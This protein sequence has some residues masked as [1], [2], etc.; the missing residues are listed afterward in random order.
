MVNEHC[1]RM[2]GRCLFRKTSDTVTRL[3]QDRVVAGKASDDQSIERPRVPAMARAVVPPDRSESMLS[4]IGKDGIQT[5][6]EPRPSQRN[7]PP[8]CTGKET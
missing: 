1:R 3:V 8:Y 6:Y 7:A 5:C 4:L 2:R